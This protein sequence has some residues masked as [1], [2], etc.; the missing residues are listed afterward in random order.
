MAC[1][2]GPDRAELPFP[3]VLPAGNGDPRI[4]RLIADLLAE[5][6]GAGRH[7]VRIVDAGCG[8]G[9]RLIRAIAQARA[10]GFVAIEGRG[11]DTDA[12]DIMIARWATR[13]WRD[14]CVG[15][16]FERSDVAQALAREED[17]GTDIL[18]CARGALERLPIAER[19][20]VA[21][22]IRRVAGRLVLADG[23]H[24]ERRGALR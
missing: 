3:S 12:D 4:T 23:H 5:M 6:Q 10:L 20:R 16:D 2:A 19:A 21:R 24:D 18:I 8:S 15:V 17:G 7:A 22:E 9:V 1:H 11:F 14:P 13:S